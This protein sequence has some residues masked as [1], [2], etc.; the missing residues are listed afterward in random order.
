M[1]KRVKC[2]VSYAD[3]EQEDG[4]SCY[5]TRTYSNVLGLSAEVIMCDHVLGEG[6]EKWHIDSTSIDGLHRGIGEE[7]NEAVR[8][9]LHASKEPRSRPMVCKP[10]ILER[11]H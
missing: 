10:K 9:G 11:K 8:S 6:I 2:L 4:R 5:V 7:E 3:L 1:K